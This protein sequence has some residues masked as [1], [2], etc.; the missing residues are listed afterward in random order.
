MNRGFHL[1]TD[2]A[3][4]QQE[5]QTRL[6][7][8]ERFRAFLL[9]WQ[10]PLDDIVIGLN[11]QISSQIDCTTCGNC[12]R[13]LMINVSAEEADRLA[14]SVNKSLDETKSL[15]L[16][17][18][19]GGQLVMNTIPCHFLNDNKC[20][21]YADRFEGCKAFPY[22]DLPGFRARIF[23]IL[24]HY[25]RCPIVYNLIESL[26]EDTNFTAE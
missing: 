10:G 11:Q 24:M 5:G 21:I 6:E 8:N 26:K 18:S 2:L 16:E 13:S 23:A 15:Y 19:I 14:S 4:L 12:C 17:E 7:E 9:N 25:D 22:L 20:S 1:Q 3:V